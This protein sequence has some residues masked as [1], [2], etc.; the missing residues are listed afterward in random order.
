MNE[1]NVI[2]SEEGQRR[3]DAIGR[4]ARE[5]AR[6]R[7]KRRRVGR[8]VAVGVLVLI[9][10]WT[11]R[12]MQSTARPRQEVRADHRPPLPVHP[13]APAPMPE[14]P[15]PPP[16]ILVSRIETDPTITSRLSIGYPPP[17]WQVIGDDDLLRTL[18]DAGHPAGLIRVNGQEILMTR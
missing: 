18:A 16:R 12:S 1:M 13:V 8:A 15:P 9:G 6:Q 10:V 2:L 3:R 5:A 11:M 7:W 4:L 17:R 14:A